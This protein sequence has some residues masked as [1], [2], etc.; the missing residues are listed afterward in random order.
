MK[1]K[2]CFESQH[3]P[4]NCEI[5]VCAGYDNYKDF[6]MESTGHYILIKPNFEISKIE[7]AVCDKEHTIL[8]IFQGQKAQDIYHTLFA[9]EKENKVEWLTDKGHMAYLGKELKKAE[10]ALVMGNSAYFQE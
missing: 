9:Y 10:L 1:K 7:V 8:K 2:T 4:E 6:S 3:K 5:I